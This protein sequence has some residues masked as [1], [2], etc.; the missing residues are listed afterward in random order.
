MG[1]QHLWKEK[2]SNKNVQGEPR[3]H[4]AD[5][6]QSQTAEP[7]S[8]RAKIATWGVTYWVEMAILFLVQ[9][10]LAV[11]WSHLE[12]HDLSWNAEELIAM[13]CQLTTLAACSFLKKDLDAA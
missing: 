5:L 3:D 2:G 6:T 12:E 13:G 1:E 10:Y 11:A 9:P 7:K 4:E 8:S